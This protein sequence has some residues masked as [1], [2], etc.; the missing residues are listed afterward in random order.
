M[1]GFTK[2]VLEIL[3]GLILLWGVSEL[4]FLDIFGIGRYATRRNFPA[5][6]KRMGL[7]TESQWS[8]HAFPEFAGTYR[9]H[10]VS[11][12][13]D[14]ASIQIALPSIRGLSLNTFGDRKTFDT[15]N[16]LLDRFFSERM[17]P[18]CLSHALKGNAE[19][20]QTM[21]WVIRKWRYKMKTM[22]I[23][24]QYVQCKMKFGNGRYIPASVAE[25]LTTDLIAIAEQLQC[26]CIDAIPAHRE[27]Q[28]TNRGNFQ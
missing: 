11:I 15:G 22:D 28:G 25:P 27:E 16:S 26:A 9:G 24:S 8:W 13:H 19:L 18:E 21:E 1:P 10:Q 2:T 12:D 20:V 6:A 14:S 4:L 23:E 5:V 17:V 3:V 7:T